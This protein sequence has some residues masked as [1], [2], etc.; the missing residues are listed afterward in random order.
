MVWPSGYRQNLRFNL[1]NGPRGTSDIII[2]NTLMGAPLV[3]AS[4]FVVPPESLLHKINH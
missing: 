4:I 2:H 3:N 1:T